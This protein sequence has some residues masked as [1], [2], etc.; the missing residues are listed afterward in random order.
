MT[1]RTTKLL[2]AIIA[3]GLWANLAVP[4]LKSQPAQAQDVSS[5]IRNIEHSLENIEQDMRAIAS[6]SCLNSRLC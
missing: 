1:D 2:L 3:L 5:S 4:L 6:G